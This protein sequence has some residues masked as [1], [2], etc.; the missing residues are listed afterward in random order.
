VVK[1]ADQTFTN[2]LPSGLH[3]FT[4]EATYHEHDPE[5]AHRVS[6]AQHNIRNVP[7]DGHWRYYC[8]KC[9]ERDARCGVGVDCGCGSDQPPVHPNNRAKHAASK[10]WASG[11]WIPL[12]FGINR[13]YFFVPSFGFPSVSSGRW[14]SRRTTLS[15]QLVSYCGSLQ[16]SVPPGRHEIPERENSG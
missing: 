6:K 1:G 7:T 8:H 9:I 14:S 3:F 16:P 4:I 2:N 15:L 12:R 5:F 10:T 11:D 13:D